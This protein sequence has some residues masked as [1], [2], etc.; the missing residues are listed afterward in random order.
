MRMNDRKQ[1]RHGVEAK[2]EY[3]QNF[4]TDESLLTELTELAGLSAQDAVLEIGA[5]MGSLTEVLAA[6]CRRVVSVEIDPDLIPY[7]ILI[8]ERHPNLTVVHESILKV[9]LQ[10]QMAGENAFHV[11][12]NI[13]YHLTS[14]IVRLLLYSRAP[15][16]SF[17]LTV[18]EEA[19]QRIAAGPGGKDWGLLGLETAYWGRPEILKR[20]PR[21]MFTPAPKVDSA[22][23]RVQP[24][25]TRRYQHDAEKEKE[26]LR[27]CRAAFAQ[28][29]KTLLNNLGP[30]YRISREEAAAILSRAGLVPDIRA[31]AMNME[32]FY[33]VFDAMDAKEEESCRA[34]E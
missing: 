23:L 7:L 18:Q 9:N 4:L 19:A 15:I 27:F 22:F 11:I 32:A 28:R 16:A 33:A 26:F 3:G 31:E 6:R 21:E 34:T 12:G 17:S 14:D 1:I 24:H 30:A 25:G 10:E 5:G 2:K 8:R 13:P 29:R 20:V